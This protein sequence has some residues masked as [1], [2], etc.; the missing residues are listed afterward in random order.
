MTLPICR[1]AK[2]HRNR[3]QVYPERLSRPAELYSR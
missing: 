2:Y 3:V 1:N